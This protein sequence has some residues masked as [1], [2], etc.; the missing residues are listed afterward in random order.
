MSVSR[1]IRRYLRTVFRKEARLRLTPLTA[2][3]S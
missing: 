2:W 1:L 3:L